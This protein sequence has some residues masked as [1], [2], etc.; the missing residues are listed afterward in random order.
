MEKNIEKIALYSL[1]MLEKE[2][3]SDAVVLTSSGKSHQ[4]K[5]VNNKIVSANDYVKTDTELFA[6]FN[7]RIVSANLEKYTIENADRIILYMKNVAKHIPPKE[8][9]NG[10][11]HG[12]FK[13]SKQ[14]FDP[15]IKEPGLRG[16]ELSEDAVKSALNAGAKRV[17][18]QMQL[19]Y[20]KLLLLTSGGVNAETEATEAYFSVRAFADKDAS[21]AKT[22]CSLELEKN[23]AVQASVAAG[24]LAAS[25]KKPKQGKQGR[26]DILFDPL[27][28][29]ALLNNVADAASIFSVESG[30][31]FF[32][33]KLN[34]KVAND[35]IT[36]YD[37][38]THP[39][40][41]NSMP[42]DIEG[43]PTKK[44]IIIKDGVLKTYL[45]NSSTAKKYGVQSTANAG[46]VMPHSWNMVLEKG[47]Q[48]FDEMLSGI[49]NGLYISNVWYTRFQ[50]YLTGEFSTIPRD[51]IFMIENGKIT[52]SVVNIRIVDSFLRMLKNITALGKDV[53]Q[54]KSWEAEIPA[55][56]PPVLVK[57]VM[58]T[59]STK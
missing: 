10:I 14:K 44:N 37:D 7:K 24:K 52:T 35:N 9:Y 12:P 17:A 25:S 36:L 21:G 53:E 39:A 43:V 57:N 3:A 28:F 19:D 26:Y 33:G 49:K 1:K 16:I 48:S 29:A 18:G 58:I 5:T 59:T 27:S 47:T 2:G 45:H 51:A 31:S 54:I 41:I 42:F 22:A 32:E 11:A 56:T 55:F 50:N 8:D 23:N 40:G 4:I 6:S 15:L 46:L 13:Y 38:A 30:D 34:E 20:K